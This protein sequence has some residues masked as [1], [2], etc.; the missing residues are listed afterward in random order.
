MQVL[1]L[2]SLAT[3]IVAFLD[4]C[5]R[6]LQTGLVQCLLIQ[7]GVSLDSGSQFLA[8]WSAIALFA[9]F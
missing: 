6:P 1:D 7:L 3:G 5:F 9:L 8:N 4:F 2:V